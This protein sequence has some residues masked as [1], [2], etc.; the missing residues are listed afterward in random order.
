M[1]KGMW[2]AYAIRL[3]GKNYKGEPLKSWDNLD[4][5]F[6]YCWIGVSEVISERTFKLE[7]ALRAVVDAHG[8]GK[9]G[10]GPW[11]DQARKVLWEKE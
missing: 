3:G 10:G 7:A 2:E 9:S 1:A 4:D 5:D 8:T 11:L 6:Q